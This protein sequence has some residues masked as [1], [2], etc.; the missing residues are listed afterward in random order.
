[1]RNSIQQIREQTLL[2]T[3]KEEKRLAVEEANK[4]N[5]YNGFISVGKFVNEIDKTVSKDDVWDALEFMK[6]SKHIIRSTKYR[7]LAVDCSELIG[8][9]IHGTN[10]TPVFT[11]VAIKQALRKHQEY[12]DAV[13]QE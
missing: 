7:R 10:G 13:E 2:E 4:L 5:E 1:M 9:T 6:Y 11:E 8:S 12:K 3:F